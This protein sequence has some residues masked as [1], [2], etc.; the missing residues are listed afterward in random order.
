[1]LCERKTKANSYYFVILLGYRV[2]KLNLNQITSE[3]KLSSHYLIGV[4]SI[5]KYMFY[6][7]LVDKVKP[8]ENSVS[9]V[10][11]TVKMADLGKL[12]NLMYAQDGEFIILA[13]VFINYYKDMYF[14]L[15]YG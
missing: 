13:A 9:Y 6:Y 3:T 14:N 11:V 5:L 7:G 10:L 12:T 8:V 2:L 1:M 4:G 15:H